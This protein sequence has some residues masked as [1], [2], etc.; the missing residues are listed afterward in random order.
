MQLDD[1]NL[2][3]KLAHAGSLS[4]TARQ[5]ELTPAAVSAALK[6]IEGELGLRLVERTT[7]SLRFTKEGEQFAQTCESMLAEWSQGKAALQQSAR[8]S[9]G[10]IRVAA[11]ADACLQF[12]G[13]WLA[14]YADTHPG[15]QI[16]TLVGD[17]MHDLTREAVD[18]AIRY[19]ALDDSS[20]TSRL[21]CTSERVL[22]ASPAYLKRFGIPKTL[23][24]LANHRCLAWLMREQ[25]KTLWRLVNRDGTAESV[26]VK[27]V[28]SGDGALVRAW[29]SEG[30]GIAYKAHIDVA[31]ELREGK[32]VRV[33]PDYRGEAV[34]VYAMLQG[35]R[36]LPMRVRSLLEYLVEQFRAL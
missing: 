7:R 25:P 12:L 11:P 14:T 36:Y 8:G 27:P 9:A 35:S 21:L 29:A 28:L 23:A 32:L 20:L 16:V 18:I 2:F 22:V 6:R 10:V 15:T 17:R 24:E 19:G 26:V 4:A 1:L 30:C 34:P 5:L 33:L 13:E 31:N 3:A